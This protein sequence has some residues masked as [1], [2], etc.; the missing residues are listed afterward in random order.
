MRQVMRMGLLGLTVVLSA[1]A[2]AGESPTVAD[3][4]FPLP[5]LFKQHRAQPLPP[6]SGGALPTP[7]PAVS[8][9]DPKL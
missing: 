9:R 5:Y 2:G 1:C 7:A 6:Y 4:V 8:D 3:T